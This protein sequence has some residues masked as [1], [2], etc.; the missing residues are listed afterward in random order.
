MN[1]NKLLLEAGPAFD[2]KGLS[3]S[4]AITPNFEQAQRTLKTIDKSEIEKIK[5]KDED[6]IKTDR[7]E[8]L[9]TAL[10]IM[11][12]IGH[13]IG[14]NYGEVKITSANELLGRLNIG[15]PGD[16]KELERNEIYKETEKAFNDKYNRQNLIDTESKEKPEQPGEEIAQKTP[17]Q[18][19]KEITQKTNQTKKQDKEES[20]EESDD[21]LPQET[22][23]EEPIRITAP[24]SIE[25]LELLR[26]KTVAGVEKKIEAI[27]ADK[28]M[29]GKIR[30]GEAERILKSYQKDIDK[31]IERA[32]AGPRS[33][34]AAFNRADS[35]SR[36]ARLKVDKA[37][38]KGAVGRTIQKGGEVV[39][40][41]KQAA[42]KGVAK[43][44]QA[45]DS[46]Q[47][48]RYANAI[49][50]VREKVGQATE[51]GLEKIGAKIEKTGVNADYNLIKNNVS[52]EAAE[53]FAGDPRS[54][55][56]KDLLKQ[57]KEK[58]A[59]QPSAIKTAAEKATQSAKAGAAT[60]VAKA[61]E[62]ADKVLEKG[63]AGVE[64][65]KQ[66]AAK[67]PVKLPPE[68]IRIQPPEDEE[69]ENRLKK[70]A[71][72]AKKKKVKK[73]SGGWRI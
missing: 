16:K 61:K 64:R 27:K 71:Q 51:K 45:L 32:K 22:P 62:V 73:V 17:D 63:K 7:G 10:H 20:D 47:M 38:L 46:E 70:L 40:S 43:V 55:T 52:P 66:A 2:F 28:S 42:K 18:P 65:V 4:G 48:K 23:E 3:R 30:V 21:A 67:K 36:D 57:A 11:A 8:N 44:G 41:L 6:L 68:G 26:A 53:Y 1:I 19:A 15:L 24:K 9:L 33:A 49:G 13:K 59:K 50:K 29:G 54:Q 5:N 12:K 25:Q 31:L 34:G 14:H 56:A 39:S 37:A 58:A 35:I 60:G 72:A 69:E